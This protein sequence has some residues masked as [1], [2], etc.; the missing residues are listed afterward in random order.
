MPFTS[1]SLCF[2]NL[3]S[4]T[5]LSTTKQTVNGDVWAESCR[6]SQTRCLR[7]PVSLWDLFPLQA[8]QTSHI[9][10]QRLLSKTSMKWAE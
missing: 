9:G 10:G 4:G 2:L 8:T 7:T 5:I 3:L 1:L 6:S